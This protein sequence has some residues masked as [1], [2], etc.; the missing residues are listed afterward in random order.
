MTVGGLAD[1]YFD[2]VGKCG[3]YSENEDPI[4][5][6]AWWCIRGEDVYENANNQK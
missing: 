2:V 5:Q 3:I 4:G 1:D 6:F